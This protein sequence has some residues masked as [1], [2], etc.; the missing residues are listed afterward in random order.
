MV[1]VV[2]LCYRFRFGLVWWQYFCILLLSIVLW[3]KNMN[4]E[5]DY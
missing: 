2:V 3:I 1:E 5:S 4:L